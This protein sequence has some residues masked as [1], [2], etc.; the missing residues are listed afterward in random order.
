M[1]RSGRAL[2]T[3]AG[4]LEGLHNPA[5]LLGPMTTQEAVLSSRIEGTQATLREVLKY[6]AGEVPVQSSKTEDIQEILNYRKAMRA[7]EAELPKRPFSLNML[8]GLHQVLLAGVRGASKTPGKF[9]VTQ[10]WIGPEGSTIETASFVPPAPEGLLD[11]LETFEAYY[12]SEQPDPLVQLAVVHAQFEILHPFADGNGR[13]GRILVPLFL[14][15]KKLLT[16]PTFYLSAWL[17]KRRDEYYARL[18]AIGRERGAWNAW[19]AFFLTAVEG[20]AIQN[21]KTARAIV[22][23]YGRL[24]ER[25]IELTR[26]QF[27]GPL[28]DQAFKQ[29]LFQ[30]LHLRFGPRAP[31][32]QAISNLLRA[33]LKDEIL[34]VVVAGAGRRPGIYALA[35]LVNLCEGKR[36]I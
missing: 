27:A 30:S 31:S 14:F 8:K 13:L 36:V 29:P 23:L 26:S 16:R 22:E 34:K 12:R 20:Q 21:S 3:Y 9:R 33:L 28:L 32:K 7:A 19:C 6:E 4:I 5:L 24:K 1:G 25:V 10:N 11:H 18:R 17:E 35:E 15:E 2:A